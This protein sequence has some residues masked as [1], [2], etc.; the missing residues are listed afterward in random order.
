MSVIDALL[1]VARSDWSAGA[2]A[3]RTAA[4][5]EPD[6]LL[7]LALA[8]FLDGG[9]EGN[10]YAEPEGFER[11]IQGGANPALYA[12]TIDALREVV[13]KQRPTTLL[14]IGCGDGR[15]TAAVASEGIDLVTLVEPSE[16]LLGE[17][18]AA[19]QGSTCTVS[20]HQMTAEA[21]VAD[22]ARSDTWSLVQS[23]F[24]FHTLNASQRHEVL[25]ALA[26]RSRSI[27]L[28]EFDV[29]DFDDG[30]TEHARYTAE[31]Y[32]R[33]LAEY[34]GD[35]TVAQRFLMPVLVGQFDPDQTR[36][37]HEQSALRWC[38]DLR[39]CGFTAVTSAPIFPYWWGT[40]VLIQGT[41]A[42]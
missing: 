38:D 25:R 41:G 20:P 12:A 4:A 3:A 8:A 1:A 42:R 22:F 24:A 29:P 18:V 2:Q 32:E 35:D 31:R 33:G 21:F 7:P 27:A 36:L 14:D 11:F 15:V 28:V 39:A 13:A 34:P 6:S 40:A 5:A 37:T 9:S 10:I 23:T 26:T 17:A 19:F 16:A 30:G